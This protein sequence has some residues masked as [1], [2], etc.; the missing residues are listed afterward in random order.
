MKIALFVNGKIGKEVLHIFS[1]RNVS[2]E[3]LILKNK[4]D[5]EEIDFAIEKVEYVHCM[6][7]EEF[8]KLCYENEQQL[9]DLGILCWW[10]FILRAESLNKARLGYLNFHPSLLPFGRGKHPNFWAFIDET[11]FGVSIHW[12]DYSIDG[13]DIAFQREIKTAWTDTG[14]T[15]YHKALSEIIALFTENLDNI[16]EG[17]IPRIKQEA[18]NEKVHYS[19]ELE[20]ASKID[21]QKLYT[22]KEMINLLRARTF[23]GYPGCWFE[24]D[25]K[26]FEVRINIEEV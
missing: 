25:G 12:V 10:P 20:P 6:S 7:Y 2:I 22:G 18:E 14:E 15:L 9:F 24:V 13:G 21:F 8:I 19:K 11:P 4:S 23:H 26:K 3:Y 16:I 5:N 1:A 17:K